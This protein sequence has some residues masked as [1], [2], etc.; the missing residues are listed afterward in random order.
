L[1]VIGNIC[2]E[3]IQEMW[4]SEKAQQLR[5]RMKECKHNC[6]FLI[7]CYKD[8]TNDESNLSL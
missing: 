2:R 6:N 8:E 3:N 5:Q 1:G 7:N 4:Y